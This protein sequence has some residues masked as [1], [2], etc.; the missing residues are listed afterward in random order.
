MD[1]DCL[2]RASTFLEYLEANIPQSCAFEDQLNIFEYVDAACSEAA[3]ISL[4]LTSAV[5]NVPIKTSPA[6]AI[7]TSTSTSIE[8][9]TSTIMISTES[10]TKLAVSPGTTPTLGDHGSLSTSAKIGIGA[11]TPLAVLLILAAIVLVFWQG[12]KR[13]RSR[14]QA[15]S[16]SNNRRQAAFVDAHQMAMGFESRDHYAELAT[17]MRPSELSA[18]GSSE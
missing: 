11:G 4:Q 1:L 9:E 15:S 12:K 10:A 5:T 3:A 14:I 7:A 18:S 8:R 16:P 13:A 17:D 2:C 6:T